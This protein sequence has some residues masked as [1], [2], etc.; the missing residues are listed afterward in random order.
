[1]TQQ[2]KPELTNHLILWQIINKDEAIM[3]AS[4]HQ[5]VVNVEK[6]KEY[7]IDAKLGRISAIQLLNDNSYLFIGFESGDT[8]VF[9]VSKFEVVPGVINKDYIMKKFVVFFIKNIIV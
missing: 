5:T 1:V 7:Q 3:S 4:Q 6:V 9:N 2:Q 8:Y